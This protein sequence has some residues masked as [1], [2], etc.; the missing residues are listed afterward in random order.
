MAASA[1]PRITAYCARCA[2][3][4]EI[5]DNLE[6]PPLRKV[7]CDGER[8]AG[9][10]CTWPTHYGTVDDKPDPWR[11]KHRPGAIATVGC[12]WARPARRLCSDG[13]LYIANSRGPPRLGDRWEYRAA[14]TLWRL[15]SA[16]MDG[17]RTDARSLFDTYRRQAQYGRARYRRIQIPSTMDLAQGRNLRVV[18]DCY[19][20]GAS[21]AIGRYL[22]GPQSPPGRLYWA[23]RVRRKCRRAIARPG[24]KSRI[25][26]LVGAGAA[27]SPNFG[28]PP[29]LCKSKA[30][31]D[32]ARRRLAD[33]KKSGILL[34]TAESI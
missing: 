9:C 11:C 29:Y 32:V 25:W 12:S 28:A 19:T 33:E 14:L 31:R 4:V 23:R 34:G 10:F 30:R 16:I 17:A 24:S 21:G 18:A 20:P 7:D 6:M 27:T 1:P 26:R 3:C 2:L 22:G 8:G 13:A 5:G 15:Y